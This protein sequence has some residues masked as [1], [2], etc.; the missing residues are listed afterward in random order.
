MAKEK[1]CNYLLT[2]TPE[3][4]S[5]FKQWSSENNVSMNTGIVSLMETVTAKRKFK[6]KQRVLE[7]KS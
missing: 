6:L 7:M 4:R 5:K 1:R 3:L 2:L